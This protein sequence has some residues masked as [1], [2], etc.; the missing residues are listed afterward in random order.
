[1]LKTVLLLKLVEKSFEILIFF[2]KVE[3]LN[4]TMQS[5]AKLIINVAIIWQTCTVERKGLKFATRK[6]Y[7]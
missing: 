6:K 5:I 2:Y 1:M 3:D 7:M 4:L